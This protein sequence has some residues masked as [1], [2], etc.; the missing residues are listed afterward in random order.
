MERIW[1]YTKD[2]D[3]PSYECTCLCRVTDEW[4]SSYMYITANYFEEGDW[5]SVESGDR[6]TKPIEAWADLSD[7]LECIG[8]QQ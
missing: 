5:C 2:D 1:H 8:F 7:I 3:L 6:I 4:C